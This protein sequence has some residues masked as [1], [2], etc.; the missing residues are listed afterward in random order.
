MIVVRS[1]WRAPEHTIS[2]SIHE[3]SQVE[4]LTITMTGIDDDR[5][6]QA[7]SLEQMKNEFVAAQQRRRA[8][9]PVAD[10]RHDDTGSGPPP[11]RP[12]ADDLASI[13]D[14]RP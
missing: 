1:F 2:E 4:G 3:A 10:S 14:L 7:Q 13:A 5:D 11:A 8:M 12:S 9:A 6:P